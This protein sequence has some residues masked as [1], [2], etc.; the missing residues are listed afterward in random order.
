LRFLASW[1]AKQFSLRMGATSLMKL[2]GPCL[3]GGGAAW[4][5]GGGV[6][7]SRAR[8]S[9]RPGG[10]QGMQRQRCEGDMGGGSG[11]GGRRAGAGGGRVVINGSI[12]GQAP[13]S[14]RGKN[15]AGARPAENLPEK[16]VYTA[17]VR[18]YDW[19]E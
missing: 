7:Q 16:G 17:R 11:G 14:G 9:V 15:A 10:R 6:P 2:T 3:A 19:T 5:A 1:Q 12:I 4:A 13:W 8:A 18:R